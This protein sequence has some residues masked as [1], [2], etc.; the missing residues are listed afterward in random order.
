V[1]AEAEARVANVEA[2]VAKAEADAGSRAVKAEAEARV[3]KVEA[4]AGARAV[5]AEAGARV[6]KAEA[7]ARVSKAEATARV[8]QMAQQLEHERLLR[9]ARACGLWHAGHAEAL[10]FCGAG[11]TRATGDRR[12]H[13]A[14]RRAVQGPWPQGRA[15]PARR[16]RCAIPCRAF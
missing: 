9:Q 11:R 5:K 15:T 3:A 14:R 13:A 7:E 8:A 4:D 2:R 1:K 12:A 16:R 6:S 10:T